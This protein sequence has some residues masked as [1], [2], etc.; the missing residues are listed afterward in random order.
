MPK[1]LYPALLRCI[2]S[3][4]AV[5]LVLSC[6]ACQEIDWQTT[7][8]RAG[9]YSSPRATDLNGDGIKD[10]VLGAGGTREWE[11]SENGVLAFDGQDGSLLWKAAC[12]NQIVG[13]PVFKDITG[14]GTDDV[15]IGGRSGQLMALDGVNGRVIWEFRKTQPGADHREDT[16]SLNFFTPQFIPD[17]NQDGTEDLLISYGGFVSAR[18]EEEERPT[19]YL[20]IFSSVDGTLIAQA[21]MPDGRETYMSPV[22]IRSEDEERVCF[23]TGG[24]TVPGHFFI[25]PLRDLRDGA[26]TEAQVLA[27]GEE[28][29]FIAPP[30]LTDL[31]HDRTLDIVVNAYEG[32]TMAWDGRTLERLWEVDMSSA[33]E[34]HAQPAAGQFVGDS[35]T[36]FFVNYCRGTWPRIQGAVQVVIDGQ[37]GNYTKMDSV[38]N[39]Q[40]ASPIPVI[41]H[42]THSEQVLLPINMKV[43][44]GYAP[45]TG[46]P[47]HAYQ[48]QLRLFDPAH[49]SSVSYC[50]ASGTNIGSTVLVEDLDQNGVSEVVFVHNDS[51]YDPFAYWG[52]TVACFPAPDF[53]SAWGQY[54][55]Q[56]GRSIY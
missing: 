7:V 46:Y 24:E 30:L 42:A 25:T 28:K 47:G 18:P 17:Q 5:C 23:G 54:L 27:R 3:S 19:G 52:V 21:P 32:K 8:E 34:T 14:D 31:N 49:G 43:E 29:G 20:M 50:T 39:L 2:R 1:L 16:T 9:T 44:T 15:F 35:T 56:D 53:S 36:D 48:T 40:Y 4:G 13:S 11:A 37:T 45:E 51:P 33:Y 55:G 22:V 12:R 26:I 10:I 41:N 38:G 6:L